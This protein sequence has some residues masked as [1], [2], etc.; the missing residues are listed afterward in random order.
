[1]VVSEPPT[2]FGAVELIEIMFIAQAELHAEADIHLVA[3]MEAEAGADVVEEGAVREDVAAVLHRADQLHIPSGGGEGVVQAEVIV[4]ARFPRADTDPFGK[5]NLEIRV[6][7]H[8][9]GQQEG[10]FKP[11]VV[12]AQARGRVAGREISRELEAREQQFGVDQQGLGSQPHIGIAGTACSDR[13]APRSADEDREAVDGELI[14]ENEVVGGEGDVSWSTGGAPVI[15]ASSGRGSTDV[16]VI[17][18]A[19]LGHG[20]G[21][22]EEEARVGRRDKTRLVAWVGATQAVM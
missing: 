7:H 9:Q 4:E 2:D 18:E 12:V 21:G 20:L 6:G 19:G 3:E 16:G 17:A 22:I 13:D 15:A 1:M 10:R 11:E 8:F 14:F 5:L